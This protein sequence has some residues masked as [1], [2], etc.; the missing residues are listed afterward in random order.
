MPSHIQPSTERI[1]AARIGH[2]CAHVG[3]IRLARFLCHVLKHNIE[4]VVEKRFSKMIVVTQ[5]CNSTTLAGD[6]AI[7]KKG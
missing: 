4:V 5:K 3:G 6:R 7:S 2:Q 1:A